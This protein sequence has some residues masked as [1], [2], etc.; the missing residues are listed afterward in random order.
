M[1]DWQVVKFKPFS[2]I[3]FPQLPKEGIE[4]LSSVEFYV[5]QICWAL[6]SGNLNNDLAQLE[7]GGLSHARW[8]TLACRIL[9]YYTSQANPGKTSGILV[10]F[11]L[12][13]S[14]PT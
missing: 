4:N 11:C 12:K 13:V 8:L 3:E 1:S 14:F 10:E 9:R 2:S 5:Y 6:I 7:V